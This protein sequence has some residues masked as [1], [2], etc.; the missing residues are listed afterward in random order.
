MASYLT[1]VEQLSTAVD[2]LNQVLQG[3]ENTTVTI[4]G[5]QQ[6][7]VQK[8]TL[9]E[10]NAKIQLVLDAAADIDAVKYTSTAAGI[11]S[12]AEFFSV[13][14]DNDESYLDLYKNESGVAV[15]KKSYPTKEKVEEIA[16]QARKNT[17]VAKS[18]WLSLNSMNSDDLTDS[19]SS[20]SILASAIKRIDYIGDAGQ[21][22]FDDNVFIGS[23]GYESDSGDD[24]VVVRVGN[25][26]YATIKKEVISKSASGLTVFDVSGLLRFYVDYTELSSYK[27]S[28]LINDFDENENPLHLDLTRYA[29]TS[30]ADNNLYGLSE[31]VDINKDEILK[32]KERVKKESDRLIEY[33]YSKSLLI[34]GDSRAYEGQVLWRGATSPAAL[35]ELKDIYCGPETSTTTDSTIEFDPRD[36]DPHIR[37]A[38]AGDSFGD[39]YPIR[40]GINKVFSGTYG[41]GLSL[42]F[43][44][45]SI[46]NLP[47]EQVSTTIRPTG[48]ARYGYEGIGSINR[49]LNIAK[50]P[51]DRVEN[52][53][54]G[55]LT[56]Q[57]ALSLLDSSKW[58]AS[59]LSGSVFIMLG[60][61]DIS[62]QIRTVQE[63]S[64]NLTQVYNAFEN[65]G[66]R[67]III[68]EHARWGTSAG[69][70]M[71][72]S[73]IDLFDG[74]RAF[75]RKY[76]NS[77]GHIYIPTF[78]ATKDDNFDDR[79]PASGIIRDNVH[80]SPYGA[81]IIGSLISEKI[82]NSSGFGKNISEFSNLFST[83]KFEGTG[84]TTLNGGVGT[85]PDNWR[86][87]RVVGSSGTITGEIIPK[88][89]GDWLKMDIDSP[90]D[91]S[92]LELTTTGDV[93]L[94]TE[95]GLTVG[96][97][98]RVALEYKY[99]NVSGEFQPEIYFQ[100]TGN[101]SSAR[102]HLTVDDT[103][104]SNEEGIYKSQ[105]IEIPESST[106]ILP[107]FWFRLN[108]GSTASVYIS[109]VRIEKICPDY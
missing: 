73:Q 21:Y 25:S 14:S 80:P 9:D 57:S 11:A 41:D 52:V 15:F 75:Q 45:S 39:W 85:V 65:I 10:V 93:S 82:T 18:N 47:T 37:Y 4:N 48:A 28:N 76:A 59:S 8:K 50:W 88:D 61:N 106:R 69:T 49:A 5:Q 46:D 2:Q 22:P 95:M 27:G 30:L 86:I 97:K 62:A 71:T 38:A 31:R 16:K 33:P 70:P 58:V 84:G 108:Q 20:I 60:T 12:G 91:N 68:E 19:A 17:V 74:V 63:I 77:K 79:R 66:L 32:N 13:V 64:D 90:S 1:L 94:L 100:F 24:I 23:F 107:T 34:F 7:S 87:R 98:V 29:Q 40:S 83:G 99:E 43:A 6:P 105:V 103:N 56:S 72:E 102:I 104:Q 26:D 96:D 67:L 53:A 78:D 51:Y 55:G 101:G 44:I 109:N 3:D 35:N 42:R 89:D 54:I 92:R 81:G 36:D